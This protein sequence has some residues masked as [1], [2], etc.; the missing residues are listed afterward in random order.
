MVDCKQSANDLARYS[1][2]LGALKDL[3]TDDFWNWEKK[4]GIAFE[5]DDY[6]GRDRFICY[7]KELWL[8]LGKCMWRKHQ[9]VYQDHL[10]YIRNDIVKPF[11]VGIL[12]Y[13]KRIM[14]IHES[15]KYLPP[16]LIKGESY[17][18]AN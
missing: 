3:S 16:P 10:K 15:E 17:D 7:E 14:E 11:R 1:C 4:D 12:R 6:L 2:D 9:S 5:G 8:E 18:A 13:S